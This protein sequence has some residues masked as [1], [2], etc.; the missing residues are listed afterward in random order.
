VI[1]SLPENSIS[2]LR[3]PCRHLIFFKYFSVGV[4]PF[5]VIWIIISDL[6]SLGLWFI[7]GTNEPMTR[8]ESSVYPH[9]DHPKGCTLGQPLGERQS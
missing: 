3:Q 2:P 7:K 8:V 1:L 6:G 4:R 9:P 5:G